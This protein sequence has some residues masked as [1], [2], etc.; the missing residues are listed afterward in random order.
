MWDIP[1]DPAN[2]GRFSDEDLKA[3]IDA[4]AR[5]V[6]RR[7]LSVPAVMALELS[8]PVAFLGYSSM[9][10]FSPMLDMVFD[11]QKVDK[12]ACILADRERI[13]TLLVAIETLEKAD[14]SAL[15]PT[16]ADLPE[17]KGPDKEGESRGH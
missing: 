4:V 16:A 10:A 9:V 1:K 15:G 11:P 14:P 7:G 13:E 6:V 2:D 5:A 17:F 3:F 8:K 12:M